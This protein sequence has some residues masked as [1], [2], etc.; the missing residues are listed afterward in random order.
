EYD[1]YSVDEETLKLIDLELIPELE[2]FIILGTWCSD[3]QREVPRFLKITEFLNLQSGQLVIIG[4]DKNKEADEIP[5]IRM[6]IELVP[7]FIFYFEGEEIGRIIESP[8]ETLEK[9]ML[10]II[11][12]I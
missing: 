3:S 8:K 1:N 12:P 2:I 6:N 4:V 7:T 9:D 5:I 10:N 11:S